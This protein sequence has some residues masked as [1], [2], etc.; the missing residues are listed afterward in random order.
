ML[1]INT[2]TTVGMVVKIKD[3]S[4]TAELSLKIPIVPFKGDRI[5]LARNYKGHWRLIGW[6]EII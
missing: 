1:S 3:K 2:A 6:G 5:G 4:K